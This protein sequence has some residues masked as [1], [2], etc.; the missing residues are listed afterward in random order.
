MP[1]AQHLT[2]PLDRLTVR[3]DYPV[4]PPPTLFAYWT[5]PALLTS[6]WP[7]AAEIDPRVGG[8][9][10]LSWPQMNWHLRGRY[11]EF[12]PGDQLAFTWNW[13]HLPNDAVDR[14]VAIDFAPLG[15]SGTALT[16][17]HGPYALTAADQALRID[18]HLAGWNHFLARLHEAIVTRATAPFPPGKMRL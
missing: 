16:L 6:W 2:T 1:E 17:T 14:I 18:D 13:D 3:A 5:Q 15:V 9:Y 12:V 4:A 8:A 7:R 11:T 10:H